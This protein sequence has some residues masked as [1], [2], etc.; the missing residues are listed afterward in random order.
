MILVDTSVW[1]DF[2]E[3]KGT[4]QHRALRRLIENDEDICLTGIVVTEILQ[5][6]KDERQNTEIRDYLLEFPILNPQGV[7]S[8][9]QAADIYR[10]CARTGMTVRKTI[11]CLI[12]AI[13][14]EHRLTL[15]HN[16]RDFT[17]IKTCCGLKTLD[18]T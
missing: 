3:G 11:D 14:L 13:A 8:Y 10:A 15:F 7:S 1:I 2:L 9:I 17:K 6:I 5:G 16:D 4:P 18:L 12:A